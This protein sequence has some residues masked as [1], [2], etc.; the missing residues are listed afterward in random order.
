MNL[1]SILIGLFALVWAFVA[2]LPLLGWMYWFILPVAVVGLAI[3]ALSSH[4][5][6]RNLNLVVLVVGAL[7]LMIGH[8]IF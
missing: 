2:F 6:G 1:I 5:G 4:R 3:G 7:R 8:G